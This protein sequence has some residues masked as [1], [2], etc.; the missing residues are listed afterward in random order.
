MDENESFIDINSLGLSTEYDSLIRKNTVETNALKEQI[1]EN[2]Y[3]I[4]SNNRL[5]A[6]GE[7][8]YNPKI[9]SA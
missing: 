6:D 8:G 7:S 4:N 9:T 5:I 1:L 2:I 3:T